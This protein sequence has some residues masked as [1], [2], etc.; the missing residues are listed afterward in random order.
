MLIPE[1]GRRSA[2]NVSCIQP[3]SGTANRD[4]ISRILRVDLDF[5]PELRDV[6][7]YRSCF[8]ACV[9]VVSPDFVE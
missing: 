6:Y 7:V 3:I 5:A 2:M 4:Q 1:R 8:Y 9:T